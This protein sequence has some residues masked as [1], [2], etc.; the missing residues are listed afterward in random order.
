MTIMLQRLNR[1]MK[2]VMVLCCSLAVVLFLVDSFHYDHSKVRRAN[3]RK[4]RFNGK[5]TLHKSD[6]VGK[7]YESDELR[8][9]G[10]RKCFESQ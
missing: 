8:G 3:L 6:I 7:V 5:N 10:N 2:I 9:L 1:L 4:L